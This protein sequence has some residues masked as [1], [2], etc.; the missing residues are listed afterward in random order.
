VSAA[1]GSMADRSEATDCGGPRRY[2]WVPALLIGALLA[3]AGLTLVLSWL[4]ALPP[5][6]IGPGPSPPWV[7]FPLVFLVFWLFVA[8]WVRPWRW[9]GARAWAFAP[10]P[11][12]GAEDIVRTRFARGEISQEQMARMLADLKA[13]SPSGARGE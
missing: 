2:G 10:V 8:V 12:V 9:W 4:G 5:L 6:G 13:T 7:V 11:S 3:L 1:I